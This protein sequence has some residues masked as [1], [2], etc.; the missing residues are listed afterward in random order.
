MDQ[1]RTRMNEEEK[2]RKMV[3]QFHTSMGWRADGEGENKC[4]SCVLT[5]TVS[6]CQELL[7]C[8]CKYA[9]LPEAPYRQSVTDLRLTGYL[10]LSLISE[11]PVPLFKANQAARRKPALQ[12]LDSDWTQTCSD[13]SP[14]TKHPSGGNSSFRPKLDIASVSLMLVQQAETCGS[15]TSFV[16]RKGLLGQTNMPLWD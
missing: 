2:Q 11:S 12:G 10:F 6:W 4:F 15:R 9:R 7:D 8:A 5:W 1:K 16:Y 13:P 14:K 3:F